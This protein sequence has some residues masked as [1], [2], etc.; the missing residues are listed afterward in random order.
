MTLFETIAGPGS[1]SVFSVALE[2]YCHG[3]R[4]A[5]TLRMLEKPIF[6]E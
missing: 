1:V 6:S 2:R 4:D 5:A 3:E